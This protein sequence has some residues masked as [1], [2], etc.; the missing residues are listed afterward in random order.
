VGGVSV[1]LRL[2]PVHGFVDFEVRHRMRG[3]IDD[4]EDSNVL[5]LAD[6]RIDLCSP[7]DWLLPVT[8]ICPPEIIHPLFD[9][10][11]D[12]FLKLLQVCSWLLKR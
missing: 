2:R 7:R 8:P 5:G 11:C 6:L 3:L 1:P 12:T 10:R 4:A 9:F